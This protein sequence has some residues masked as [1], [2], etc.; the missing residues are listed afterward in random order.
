MKYPKQ[1]R[2]E[3]RFIIII[4]IILAILTA[5]SQFFG[6]YQLRIMNSIT[7]AMYDHPLKVSTSALVIKSEIFKMHRDMKDIFLSQS[8]EEL[9]NYSNKVDMHE[10]HIYSNL[11]I[12]RH[13]IHNDHEKKLID[14]V[15]KLFRDWNP[16][17]SE[18]IRLVKNG[19]KTKAIA[20]T[21]NTGAKHVLK[22][23]Q[24]TQNLY[25]YTHKTAVKFKND[26]DTMYQNLS[27]TIILLGSFLLAMYTFLAYFTVR[28]ISNYTAKNDHLTGVI[29]VI[30]DINQLIVRVTNRKALIQESCNILVSNHVYGN[31][32]I[33]LYDEHKRIEYIASSDT[34]GNFTGFKTKIESGWVPPCIEKVAGCNESH[35]LIKNTKQ[36]CP[37]CPLSDRYQTKGAFSIQLKYNDKVYGNISLS[38]NDA[39]IY[40]KEEIS[41][42]EE[43]A[44]DISYALN[45]FETQEHLREQEKSLNYFKEL[46]KIL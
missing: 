37:E 35:L 40:D 27:I 36:S 23:E 9:Q 5:I 10:Q 12:I 38:V 43:V 3:I 15:E 21:Q 18:I 4:F 46:Y 45:N 2:N 29:S 16:I 14:Q 33:A 25:L 20:I 17:R 39:Y 34:S 32:F 11:A 30:R 31:A 6:L 1:S 24:S 8:N 42:L 44:G 26:S 13:N 19:E 7:N 22:L 41:L 28:R